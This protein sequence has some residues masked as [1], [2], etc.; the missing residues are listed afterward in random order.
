MT[1]RI[2]MRNLFISVARRFASIAERLWV[3]V[4]CQNA[5]TGQAGRYL[6]NPSPRWTIQVLRSHGASIGN[7]TTI[8]RSLYL[9]NVKRDKNSTGD[10]RHIRIGPN[11]YVGDQVYFDLANTITLGENTILSGRVSIITH[12]DGNRS[13]YLSRFFPRRCAPVR[14]GD[15]AW[16]GFGSTILC[17]VSVGENTMIAAH[18]L[19][20][21]DVESNCLYAGVPAKKVRPLK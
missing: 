5:F 19:V 7:G 9:D 17:G 12:A 16:V 8:K 14:I 18:S 10:F 2:L 15:G 13:P 6:R 1:D 4:L 21:E 11:C 3:R 20:T